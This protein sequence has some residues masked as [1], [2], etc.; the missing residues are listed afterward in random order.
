MRND[1]KHGLKLDYW[2]VDQLRPYDRNPRLNDS[3]VG[4]MVKAME[5]FGFSVPLL[6]RSDGLAIDEHLRLKAAP[7]GRMTRAADNRRR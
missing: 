7:S 1:L 4:K 5:R 3:V 2:P 6:V